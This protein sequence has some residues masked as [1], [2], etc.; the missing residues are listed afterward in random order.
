MAIL[1][2][3][4][5]PYLILN[6]IVFTLKPFSISF[7][8]NFSKKK[9]LPLFPFPITPATIVGSSFLFKYFCFPSLLYLTSQP[10]LIKSL[11]DVIS[12]IISYSPFLLSDS[13]FKPKLSGI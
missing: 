1:C 2:S 12:N 4:L 9:D 3:G 7:P 5:D 11:K 13:N 10:P 6:P 8:D